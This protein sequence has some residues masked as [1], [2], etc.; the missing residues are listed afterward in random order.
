MRIGSKVLILVLGVGGVVWGWRERQLASASSG[1]AHRMTCKQL[2]ESGPGDNAHVILTDFA[3][4]H[5]WVYQEG[6]SG[7]WRKVWIPA[8]PFDSPYV[9]QVRAAGGNVTKIAVPRPVRVVVLAKDVKDEKA[10]DALADRDEI[11]GMVINLIDRLG[12]EEKKLLEKSYG[13]VSGAQIFE[14][15]RTAWSTGIALLAMVAGGL[16]A[17]AALVLFFRRSPAQPQSRRAGRMPRVSRTG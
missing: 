1:E 11:D 2:G 14:V 16:V 6:R 9:E 8:V 15:G 7:G 3:L 17:L 10:L 12:G 4:T 5:E 13:D